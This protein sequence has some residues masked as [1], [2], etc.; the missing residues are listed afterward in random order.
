MKPSPMDKLYPLFDLLLDQ[1]HQSIPDDQEAQD[2][3]ILLEVLLTDRHEPKENDRPAWEVFAELEHALPV[4]RSVSTA[5]VT[6]A[7][8]SCS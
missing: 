7:T 8:V 5:S 1:M 4:G 6:M 2:Q 3:L